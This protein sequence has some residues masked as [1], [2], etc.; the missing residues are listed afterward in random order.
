MGFKDK[1]KGVWETGKANYAAQRAEGAE[2]Q[3][4]RKAAYEEGKL[5]GIRAKGMAEMSASRQRGYDAGRYGFMGKPQKRK[6]S[7]NGDVFGFADFGGSMLG[8]DAPRK[9]AAPRK[10]KSSNGKNIHI[11]IHK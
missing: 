8:M 4:R 5:Q 9:K 1:L 6:S 11:H 3:R 7:F 2:R 10:K